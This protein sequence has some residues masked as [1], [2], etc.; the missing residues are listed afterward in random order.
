MSIGKNSTGNLHSR[1]KPSM[2]FVLTY[3]GLLP[4]NG[5]LRD[6]HRI[7]QHLHPQLKRLWEVE[8][9]LRELPPIPE[10]TL[11]EQKEAEKAGLVQPFR[12]HCGVVITRGDFTWRPLVTKW[13]KLVCSLDIIMLRPEEPGTIIRHG[14]DLDN[15][16]KSGSSRIRVGNF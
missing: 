13:L 15:R 1:K 11:K 2:H 16:M 12:L 14:G 6:K 9:S 4:P 7:R 10:S 5:D 8:Q 3:R